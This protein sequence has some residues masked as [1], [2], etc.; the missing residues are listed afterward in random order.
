MALALPLAKL[1]GELLP[2][3]VGAVSGVTSMREKERGVLRLRRAECNS[4]LSVRR[5]ELRHVV[6]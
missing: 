6:S 1:L 2:V 3:A 5:E 4:G